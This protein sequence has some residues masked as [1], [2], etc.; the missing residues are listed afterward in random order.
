MKKLLILA[1]IAG[2]VAAYFLF[3][4]GQYLTL[5]GI[6]RVSA[7]VSGFYEENPAL[8]LGGFFAIYVAVT[9][10]SLPGAPLSR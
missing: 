4:L 2:L 10:A 6:K 1:A 7:D 3:D 5:E 9:A 8:V